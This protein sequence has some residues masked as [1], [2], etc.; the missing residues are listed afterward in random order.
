[1]CDIHM[2]GPFV[3]GAPDKSHAFIGEV[4]RPE[5]RLRSDIAYVGDNLAPGKSL[6][7]QKS[8]ERE[9]PA[10]Q[11]GFRGYAAAA[12][13]PI[14][15]GDNEIIIYHSVSFSTVFVFKSTL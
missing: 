6:L 4:R 7:L 14:E 15:S 9:E 13:Q 8:Y 5:L 2:S 10:L 12:D 11:S 3:I 1:M